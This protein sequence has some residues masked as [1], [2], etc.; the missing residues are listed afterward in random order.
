MRE[1]RGFDTP[2]K[3]QKFQAGLC[4]I[5]SCVCGACTWTGNPEGLVVAGLFYPRVSHEAQQKSG[6]GRNCCGTPPFTDL[7]DSI[8]SVHDFEWSQRHP[9]MSHMDL[10]KSTKGLTLMMGTWG[11]V[12]PESAANCFLGRQGSGRF[13]WFGSSSAVVIMC[14]AETIATWKDMA[15]NSAKHHDSRAKG[16]CQHQPPQVKR[17]YTVTFD[18]LKGNGLSFQPYQDV[19]RTTSNCWFFLGDSNQI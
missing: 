6:S 4:S 15:G 7:V 8:E 10:S 11:T 1:L 9:H 16:L 17:K 3:A 2:G 19:T 14:L 18:W 5:R 13:W 12:Y